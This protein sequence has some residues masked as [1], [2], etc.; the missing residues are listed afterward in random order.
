M[1]R[2]VRYAL[3]TLLWGAVVGY[4]VYSAIVVERHR[5][6]QTVR[7]VDVNIVDSSAN[8][9]LVHRRDVYEWIERSGVKT[10]GR[11]CR[12]VDL[13]AIERT[14]AHNGFVAK[15]KAYTSYSGVLTIDVSQR[16]PALRLLIDGYN[17]YVTSDGFVFASPEA[18]AVYM[19][20]VTGS[21]R[22]PFSADYIGSA[23]HH[24]AA[25]V[26]ASQERIKQIEKEKYPLYKREVD[27]DKALRDLRR[28][29]VKKGWFKAKEVYEREIEELKREKVVGRRKLKYE[30][31]L[32]QRGIDVISQ[33]QEAERLAQKKLLK[34]YEDFSKLITF[35]KFVEGDELLRAE[36]VQIVASS[37]VSGELELELVPR[38]G[39]H[40]IVF[41]RIED[42]EQKFSKLIAFYRRGFGSLGWSEYKT[43]NLKYK[44][45]VVCTK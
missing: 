8:G 14:V 21:Y 12:Q 17:S 18:S 29:R 10:L 6:S 31:L 19:P 15:V 39:D 26:A 22:P 30:A 41:G 7:R 4:V 43:I 11:V 2:F 25:L 9:N 32:I 1:N 44:N 33:K 38:S 40:I 23:E 3:F 5:A 36:I 13:P 28:K 20:I 42:V 35:V 45:Q 27:N 37:S 34:R 24:I 16:R